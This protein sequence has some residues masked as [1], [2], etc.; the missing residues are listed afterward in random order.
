MIVAVC[1]V[2][3]IA[4]VLVFPAGAH[5]DYSRRVI[6]TVLGIVRDLQKLG[7][8]KAV[9]VVLMYVSRRSLVPLCVEMQVPLVEL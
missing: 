4:V 9:S 5:R 6:I 7:K 1:G 2:V 3:P 8:G